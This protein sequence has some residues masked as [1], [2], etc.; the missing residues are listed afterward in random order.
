MGMRQT[1]RSKALWACFIVLHA[2]SVSARATSFRDEFNQE[3]LDPHWVVTSRGRLGATDWVSDN[4]YLKDG[5]L[6]LRHRLR[7]RMNG[8]EL[9]WNE[10]VLY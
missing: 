7:P 2:L 5:N 10:P 9:K 3:T 8:A 1:A 6:I 4:V